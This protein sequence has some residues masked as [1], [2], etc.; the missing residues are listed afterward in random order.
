MSKRR[1]MA[2]MT[3]GYLLSE[4]NFQKLEQIRNQLFLM[5]ITTIAATQAEEQEPL[6]IHRSVLGQS[7]ESVA[8]ELDS[9]LSAT[10][11]TG[12]R[13]SRAQRRH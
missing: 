7:F 11:W 13:M 2:E 5:A 4:E 1:H 6:E 3:H 9:V 10:E 12:S 8:L